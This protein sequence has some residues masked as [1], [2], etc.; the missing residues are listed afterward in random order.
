MGHNGRVRRLVFSCIFLAAAPTAVAAQTETPQ[1]FT[2]R[3]EDAPGAQTLTT[4]QA[5]AVP[6][7]LD[8]PFR[9]LQN[10]P[11][12]A[13]A[14][15]GL[16]AEAAIRG[17]SPDDTRL[18]VDGHELPF[19]FHLAGLKGLLHP[20]L[21]DQ[22]SLMPT[23][24]GAYY[25]RATGG[26]VDTHLLSE[27]P[28]AVRWGAR[29][30]LLDAGA[31]VRAPIKNGALAV[32]A[33]RSYVDLLLRP[34]ELDAP[35]PT[36]FDYQLK[37][38]LTAGYDSEWSILLFGVDDGLE[39]ELDEFDAALLRLRMHRLQVRW[40][41]ALTGSR[42]LSVS[43]FAGIE[44]GA[45]AGGGL[46]PST[47][48]G[49]RADYRHPFQD[50]WLDVGVDLHAYR[51]PQGDPQLVLDQRD[52][53]GVLAE[54]LSAND[55]R[56][57]VASIG[58]YLQARWQIA[59]R[60][61]ATSG[62]RIDYLGAA[63]AGFVDPRVTVEVAAS[64]TTRFHVTGGFYHQ[65]ARIG[66]LGLFATDL[67]EAGFDVAP[68][69]SSL[70][71]L[72]V[73]QSLGTVASLDLDAFYKAMP[74]V[75]EVYPLELLAYEAIVPFDGTGRAYG[76]ELMLRLYPTDRLFG[77]VSY[78][79]SRAEREDPASGA[80]FPSGYDRT[81]NVN[82]VVSYALT[83]SLTLGVRARYATGAP[84][85]P[86][87]GS[88]YDSDTSDYYGIF[89]ER[90][91][92]RTPDFV[93]LDVRAEQRL[94]RPSGTRFVFFVEVLNVTNHDNDV[95]PDYNFDYTR[96]GYVPSVPIVPMLGLEVVR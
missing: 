69:Q 37:A 18:L 92:E 33:R 76:A 36:Y 38:D 75:V 88:V 46:E 2:E 19:L 77:W 12:S 39:G 73:R 6:G 94:G 26:V 5:R 3:E 21:I 16:G 72:G 41:R 71:L 29:S 15:A 40:R 48:Y 91:S 20:D 30:D 61:R 27:K 24:F 60:V 62:L 59:D 53:S 14:F 7:S 70:A 54:V 17:S 96:L 34:F 95:L 78:T 65:P 47:R 74:H 57:G 93:Q 45:L 83:A 58:T 86:Y 28:D 51:P 35:V 64:E 49:V 63:R 4:E 84:F 44:Q 55:E 13:P 43:G 8:D 90:N 80:W 82:A 25:G 10:F 23:G 1:V 67:G 56:R 79:I 52:S 22:V 87:I 11:V 32:A 81:H 68:E 66:V 89:G 50:V 31:F 42:Y 9:A 85:T